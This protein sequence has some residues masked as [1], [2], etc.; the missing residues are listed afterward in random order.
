MNC[1]L[2]SG[3]PHGLPGSN[4][5][6][7]A[8]IYMLNSW[9]SFYH[10]FVAQEPASLMWCHKPRQWATLLHATYRRLR[11]SWVHRARSKTIHIAASRR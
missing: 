3:N 4:Q 6:A 1:T 7:P 8:S 2:Q 9:L 10:A 11:I 5:R